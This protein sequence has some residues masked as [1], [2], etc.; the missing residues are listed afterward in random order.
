LFLIL[1]ALV[2]LT[3]LLYERLRLPSF[4][5]RPVAF[6]SLLERPG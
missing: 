4:C 3:R 6:V 5:W 2:A 1:I